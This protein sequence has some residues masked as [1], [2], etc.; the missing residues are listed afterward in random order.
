[1]TLPDAASN[2]FLIKG[3]C[4]LTMDPA[5]GHL[6]RGD[7]RI[8]DGRIVEVSADLAEA[9]EAVVDAQGK[10]VMPGFVEVHWH[11]WNSLWRGLA[12]EATG[13]FALHRLAASYTPE[14]HYIAV[15]YAA[16]EAI[17]AGITTCHDWANALADQADAMAHCRALVDSGIRARFGYGRQP[18]P[19]SAPLTRAELSVAQEWLTAHAEGRVDLGIVI[20]KVENLRAEVAAARAMGL[21]T[22]APHV[23]LANDL[24]L[25]GPEF[26]FTHGPGTPDGLMALLAQRGV[27][28]GLCPSTDPLIGAGLPPLAQFMRNGV[29]F[30]DIGFSVDV[31]CQSCADP[32]AA[33]RTIKNSARITQQ[34]GRSFEQIIFSP[35]NADDPTNGLTMPRQMLQLATLNGARILGLEQTTGSLTPGKRAD[36][37]LVR[38]DDPNMLAAPDVNPSFQ[39]VQLGQPANVDTV[40]VDGRVLKRDGRLL[41]SDATDIGRKAVEAIARIRAKARLAPVDVSL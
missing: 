27:K 21:K 28:I 3:G 17:N 20:H 22:I 10:I 40:I 14:D 32:F 16:L 1:M 36:V 26:I 18:A 7:V 35:P 6:P 37:I 11:M 41:A 34:S 25:L 31:T 39:L 15:R 24:D 29:P 8:R 30:E 13:Y 38:T 4:V 19:D 12:H 23:N 5:L 2:N 9:G 33:M